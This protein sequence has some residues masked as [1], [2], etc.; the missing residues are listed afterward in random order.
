MA[1]TTLPCEVSS[2]SLSS[3]MGVLRS[4]VRGRRASLGVS[5]DL[6]AR[7]AVGI[8]DGTVLRGRALL[9]LVDRLHA[10]NDLA[11]HGILIVEARR[12][13]EH[14]EEL[15]VGRI[16]ILRA[17]HADNAALERDIGELGWQVGIFRSAG[18]VAA[19]AVAGLRHE[20][21]DDAMERHVVVVLLPRQR[22]DALGML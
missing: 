12:L 3:L 9:D 19:L 7:D 6:H 1:T 15:A 20:T 14:D 22:L 13:G 17:R 18:A 4:R 8:A 10:G 21:G 5:R 16:G 11:H 2:T